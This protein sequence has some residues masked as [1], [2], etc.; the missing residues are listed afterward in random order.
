M[1]DSPDSK[2]LAK[3][4][5]IGAVVVLA[6]QAGAWW[7]M[8]AALDNWAAR[9]AFGDMFGAV[10][11][12]FSGLALAGVI[13]AIY[14]QSQE[15]RLQRIALELTRTELA[16]SSEAQSQEE[17]HRGQHALRQEADQAER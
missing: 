3:L 7:A 16:Q 1:P 2:S 17:G 13:L 8:L 14:L 4:L 15:L 10:N 5:S 6:V 9:A 12:L 11:T